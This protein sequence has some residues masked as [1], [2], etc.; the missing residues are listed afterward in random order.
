MSGLDPTGARDHVRNLAT[1]R[2]SPLGCFAA[3][4]LI[5]GVLFLF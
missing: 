3:L 4:A 5:A 1:Q 2:V